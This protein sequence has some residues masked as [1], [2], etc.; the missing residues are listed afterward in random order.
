MGEQVPIALLC[1]HLDDHHLQ[2]CGNY[3]VDIEQ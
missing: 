3:Q 1:E 2:L